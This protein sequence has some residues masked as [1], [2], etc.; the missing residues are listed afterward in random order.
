MDL[1]RVPSVFCTQ[2][3]PAHRPPLY[4]VLRKPRLYYPASHEDTSKR[5]TAWLNTKLCATTCPHPSKENQ[6]TREI[7][8]I[9]DSQNK[10]TRCVQTD[11]QC[12]E[13]KGQFMSGTSSMKKKRKKNRV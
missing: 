13:L 5:G 11:C 10:E 4:P 6:G 7:T 3:P 8:K 9:V 12:A 1:H 2:L